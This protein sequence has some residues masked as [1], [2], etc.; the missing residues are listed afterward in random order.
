MLFWLSL[1]LIVI[2]VFI[3]FIPNI[4]NK[5]IDEKSHEKLHDF[6]CYDGDDYFLYTGAIIIV[7]SAI[8]AVIMLVILSANQISERIS[9]SKYQERYKALTYKIESDSYRD[10]FGLLN[11]EVIDEIQDWNEDLTFY[12]SNQRDFWIG[13]FI[14]NIYDEFEMID[15]EKFQ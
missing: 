4:A 12:K 14:P 1:I 2:G 7:I 6:L 13:I 10:D 5:W 11:K 3:V 8:S 9:L 15:Y